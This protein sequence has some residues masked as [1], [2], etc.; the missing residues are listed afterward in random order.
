MKYNN[1]QVSIIIPC[2]NGSKYINR[3]L[4]ALLNQTYNNIQV[5][6][7]DDGSEDDTLEKLKLFVKEFEE[8]KIELIVRH[9]ENKGQAAAINNALQYVNGEFL[10]WQ[11]IDDF[12][13]IDAIQNMVEFIE[14]MKA[15]FIRGEV[16]YLAENDLNKIVKIGKSN[17]PCNYDIFEKYIYQNDC[18]SFVGIFMVRMK[19]FDECIR[20]R[21]I[22]ESRAGQNWQLILPL[23]Y[24]SKCIYLNKIIYNQVIISN[25]HSRKKYKTCLE[26][27]NRITQVEEVLSNTLKRLNVYEKY[28]FFIKEKYAREK[29]NCAFKYRD[30]SNFLVFYNNLKQIKRLNIKDK[31]KKIIIKNKFMY[32]L[33]KLIFYNHK[34]NKGE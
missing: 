33:Y 18:Y 2:Y 26:E 3:C 6:V 8:K 16:A 7:I 27:I 28:E 4:N 29:L 19:Y 12:Y 15:N 21:K 13:N 9:Q 20:D 14:K 23:A 1:K 24:S 32:N 17:E 34:D 30:K 22:Y 10:C 31:I 11:D 5:I 25:S